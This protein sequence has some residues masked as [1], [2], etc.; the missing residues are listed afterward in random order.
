M[1]KVIRRAIYFVCFR[2]LPIHNKVILFCSHLG[3]NYACNPRAIYEELLTDE[4]FSDYHFIWAFKDMSSNSI[5]RG[6]VVKYN[7]LKYLYYLSTSKYWVFNA[8]M[9]YCYPKKRGQIYLQTWHGTPLKRLA[10]DIHVGE[11]AKFYRS[12]MS[13]DEMTQSY[14]KDSLR[15]DYMISANHFSTEAFKSAFQLEDKVMIETGYPRND[16]LVNSGEAYIQ[17]LK[18]KYLIS[19]DK[20]VILYAPTWRDNVYDTN[21]YIF[22]LKVDFQK[23][24]DALG[25]DYVIIYKPHYLIHN[26]SN[27]KL[28][29]GFV[30]DAS[31][32]EDINDLYLMSD[33]LI[34][35]YSSVF[36]DYGVLR[37]PVLFYMYDLEEYRDNLRG[38]YLDIYKDLPGPILKAEGDVLEK[39]LNI[40]KVIAEYSDRM[41]LFYTKFCALNDGK[42]SKKV[43]DIVFK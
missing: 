42:S 1:T 20:I 34:T 33:L 5:Q 32:C 26:T 29:N 38:F 39:I 10:A 21:G 43:I 6:T 22:E 18:R 2:Y 40:E 30:Y 31:K 7:S 8:K 19:S 3:K 27:K 11:D 12:E 4:R 35:D 17:E 24:Y 13:K 41:E 16:V 15:Y 9:L 36:F 23:W 37:R 28:K 14:L 25:D